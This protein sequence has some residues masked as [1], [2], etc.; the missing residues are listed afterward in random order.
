[1]QM[2]SEMRLKK[3]ATGVILVRMCGG[4]AVPPFGRDEMGLP[5][6]VFKTTFIAGFRSENASSEEKK[7]VL[8]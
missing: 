6:V 1:M 2:G 7:A 3:A 4:H 8:Y 5:V